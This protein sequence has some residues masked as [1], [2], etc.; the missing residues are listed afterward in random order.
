MVN[1]TV[2]ETIKTA[3]ILIIDDEIT[4]IRL[5]ELILSGAGFTN[6]Y[7]TTDST[8]ALPLY[9]S[10]KPD[11]IML[12]L[13]M[14]PP[15][16]FAILEQLKPLI[17][18][19]GY[20]PVLVLTADVNPRAKR[21][22]LAGG[23]KDFLT[24]PVDRMEVLLRVSNLLETRLRNSILEDRVRERTQK[25]EEAQIETLSRLALAAEYR[26]DDTGMHTRR[27]GV[28]AARL[29]KELGL[30][31]AQVALME[32]AAPLHDI[33]KI[34]ISDTIL[35]KPGKLTTEE[36]ELMKSHTTIGAGI[37]SGSSSPWLHMAEVIALS[38]HE[39]WEG[40]GYPHGLAGEDIPIEGRIVAIVDVFDALVNER[41]YKK[42]WPVA[43]ALEEIRK[44]EG[45]YFDPAVVKAFF[46]II[47]YHQS[48]A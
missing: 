40:T 43:D 38:H 46:K 39:R 33:G 9:N 19:S 12:D 2:P 17:E 16:G 26:D 25:L 18:Q 48:T 35:L 6:V 23:A 28:L 45:R 47:E 41:P 36:F 7:S 15:D 8:E 30:D 31:P 3:R 1:F 37:L 24:K 13:H 11:L 10:Y 44:M 27:V 5:I 14:A 4:N 34:G 20:M 29:A 32:Q 22:A 42:A 21:L